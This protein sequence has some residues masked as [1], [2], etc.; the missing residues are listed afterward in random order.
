MSIDALATSGLGRSGPLG[1]ATL[2]ESRSRILDTPLRTQ[3]PTPGPIRI[4]QP[5]AF[6][7]LVY[8]APLMD[9]FATPGDGAKGRALDVQA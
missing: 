2:P 7:A 8:T 3:V 6:D 1:L 4:R 5:G 9:V